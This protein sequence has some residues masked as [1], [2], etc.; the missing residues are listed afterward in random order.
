[1]P[2]I[3]ILP[4]DVSAARAAEDPFGSLPPAQADGIRALQ[5]RDE[6]ITRGLTVAEAWRD[7]VSALHQ[8]EGAED[9]APAGF[10]RDFLADAD[11]GRS[12]AL[13]ST[14]PGQREALDDDLQ[15]LRADLGDRAVTAEAAGLALRRRL[16][17]MQVLETYAGGV[18]EDPG[19]FDSADGRIAKL[20]EG[21]GLPEARALAVR[22]EMRTRLANSAVDGL[23]GDPAEAEAALRL[24]L[25]DDVLPKEIKQQRLTEAATKLQ[26]ARLL[27]GERR[28]Q[29]LSRRA[30]EGV[31][32]DAEIDAALADGGLSE[33]E[34]D[35]LRLQTRQAQQ[36]AEARRARID[37]VASG[38]ALDPADAEDRQAADAYWEDVSEAYAF[39]D[40][41]RRQQAELDL[42]RRLGVVPDGLAKKYR[43]MLLSRDP[44]VVVN[45]ARAITEIEGIVGPDPGAI[46]AEDRGRAASITEFD[47]LGVAADRA[48]EL[49]EKKVEEEG[50]EEEVDAPESVE[51]TP[52]GD[53]IVDNDQTDAPF[54]GSEEREDES[55]SVFR[56]PDGSVTVIDEDTGDSVEVPSD[57]AQAIEEAAERDPEAVQ[58]IAQMLAAAEAVEAG[59]DS[60]DILDDLG[61]VID[62]V[63]PAGDGSERLDRTLNR[64][65]KTT[66]RQSLEDP[67]LAV[68]GAELLLL[69]IDPD[70]MGEMFAKTGKGLAAMLG[71]VGGLGLAR[72]LIGL[73]ARQKAQPGRRRPDDDTGGSGGPSSPPELPTPPSLSQLLPSDS[74]ERDEEETE[75]DE[76]DLNQQIDKAAAQ[77]NFDIQSEGDAVEAN[78]D[79][80]SFWDTLPY[81]PGTKTIIIRLNSKSMDGFVRVH[82]P[83]N[84]PGQWIMR[85]EQLFDASGKRLSAEELQRQ[86]SLPQ[87]DPPTEVSDV[88][89]PPGTEIRI[90]AVNPPPDGQGGSVVQYDLMKR[91]PQDWFRNRRAINP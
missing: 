61:A 82:G 42:V 11:R 46:P 75:G 64:R 60:S 69:Q 37:R 84:Q 48:I 47:D 70:T 27:D 44:E 16:G 72:T 29:A 52:A 31:A 57:L 50:E 30:A 17:L 28:W 36:D 7:G 35:R 63:F 1:M 86:F 80:P 23:M 73:L 76:A 33:S 34:A 8:A 12:V 68:G 15:A 49:A 65:F 89:L 10:A 32:D 9:G 51:R 13:R 2:R 54:V 77:P 56:A 45:G 40:P 41:A 5:A 20:V 39:D 21:L 78:K 24:G 62:R 66:L 6:G 26:R 38:A 19:L 22:S 79:F 14:L 67:D 25:Y 55:V 87:D 59:A 71:A 3:P 58:L 43:G 83:K 81:K 85:K 74:G 88:V 53:P 18:A 90:G 4:G 91:P